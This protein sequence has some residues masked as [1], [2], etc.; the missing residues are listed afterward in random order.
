VRTEV[1]YYLARAERETTPEEE[2]EHLQR[3]LEESGAR[4]VKYR[5]RAANRSTVSAAS[6]G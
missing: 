5:W 6:A 2:V 1:T 4:A 3:P